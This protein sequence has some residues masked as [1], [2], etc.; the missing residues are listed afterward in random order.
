MSSS[1]SA[2]SGLSRITPGV[3]DQHVDA[4]AALGEPLDR[5]GA[6]GRVGDVDL[7]GMDLV[8]GV[9]QLRDDVAAPLPRCR[10]RRT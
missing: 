2:A 5:G 10:D 7:L 8:A 4:S 6:G 9:A 3:V 1:S